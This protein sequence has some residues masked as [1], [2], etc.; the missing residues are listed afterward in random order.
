MVEVRNGFFQ[1]AEFL[2]NESLEIHS[3]KGRLWATL[4]QLKHARAEKKEDFKEVYET[5]I[6]SLQE[7]PKS[8]EVWCEGARLF[9]SNHPNNQ[10]YDLQKAKRYLEFAIQFTP[11]YGDSFL[12]MLRLCLI[13]NDNLTLQQVR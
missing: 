13:M 8:G 7:I 4:I 12:E 3:A 6:Y 9:T 10:Y 11:Q 5:F 1:E 2:V